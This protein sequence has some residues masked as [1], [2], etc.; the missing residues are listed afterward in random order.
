[1]ATI[2]TRAGKG[3]PLTN[4]EVDS[5]FTGLNTELV[6]KKPYHG[7][8]D[9]TLSTISFT[10][11][12]LTFTIAPTSTSFDIY[13]QGTKYTKTST[14]ITHGVGGVTMAVG[15]NYI[16]FDSAGTLQC[17]Q[18]A[19]NLNTTIPIATV[20]L[21]AL[22]GGAHALSEERHSATRCLDWH[23]WAHTT[24]GA[25]YRSGLSFTN[26]STAPSTFSV[27]TGDIED[28]DI[29]FTV[30]STQTTCR[31]WYQNGASSYTFATTA[32]NYP[33]IWNGGTTRARYPNSASS[34]ALTD[35]ASG[36]YFNVW[37]YAATD[38]NVPVYAFTETF[39][40]ASGGY[41]TVALARAIN[42]PSLSALGLSP[43]L[44]LLYR[45]I[46]LGDGNY[47]ESTDYRSSSP[48]PGGGTVATTAVSVSFSPAGNIASTNVQSAIEE[49]DTEKEPAS[50]TFT[51][52]TLSGA[53]FTDGYTEETG[54]ANTSTAY[55][56]NLANGTLQILTLTGN[57]SYT[58]P[59]ATAGKSFTLIQ[60]QDGTGSRTV[61]W[62]ASVK[63]PSS[64]A[65]TIT[66]TASK[67]D[68]FV[69][70]ADGTYWLGS[71]AGQNYY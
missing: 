52:K 63:W 22:T 28:E 47:V 4:T 5:N 48:V 12:T 51:G 20:Y 58:F 42:P 65:P 55:T 69:F 38:M 41:T 35:F 56:I 29:L 66:S 45:V 61:T 34:Y 59:T 46:Y 33:F 18:S 40:G 43:E 6:A 54:T 62:P 1:M 11:A 27:S 16:Y 70:T 53:I 8:A 50:S 2:V 14:S 3:S 37:V 9:R 7:V 24:I 36:R 10:Y 44:K 26:T 64:T 68:K 25:R 32:S 39:S 67:A 49:L 19:W 71:V 21:T 15:L 60:K 57:C 17:S 13:Y 31:T 30:N 23:F